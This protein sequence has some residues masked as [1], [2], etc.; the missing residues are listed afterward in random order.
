MDYIND[1]INRCL[2]L[3][4]DDIDLANALRGT[5]LPSMEAH[6]GDNF[7]TCIT[8]YLHCAWKY[9]DDC[10]PRD[11][12][13]VA[14]VLLDPAFGEYHFTCNIRATGYIND[15]EAYEDIGYSLLE[16]AGLDLKQPNPY[17]TFDWGKL[18]L[19]DFFDYEHFA[20]EY[21]IRND[22]KLGRFGYLAQEPI[23]Y[24]HLEKDVIIE[25]ANY[26]SGEEYDEELIQIMSEMV[27]NPTLQALWCV[28]INQDHSATPHDLAEDLQAAITAANK[29]EP[30][31]S[32][33][34]PPHLRQ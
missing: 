7:Y 19:C 26:L 11:L 13:E 18:N 5:I 15:S 4:P 24:I 12:T 9:D 25:L 6:F 32:S 27:D 34:L 20:E 17:F 16:E 33:S 30:L 29:Q 3:K 2:N 22:C 28:H 23:G 1:L 21:F 8:D 31:D 14:D 10:E